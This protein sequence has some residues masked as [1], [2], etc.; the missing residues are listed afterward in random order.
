[1]KF[2]ATTKGITTNFFSPLSFVPVFGS[3]IRDPRYGMGKYQ[4]PGSGMN[5]LDTQ[6]WFLGASKCRFGCWFWICLKKRFKKLCTKY[7]LG[8]S[9][10][11][12]SNTYEKAQKN[13]FKVEVRVNHIL[14]FHD[15]TIK[16]LKL[17]LKPVLWICDI[18][19]RVWICSGS[20]S[21]SFRQWLCLIVEESGSRS[22]SVQ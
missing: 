1:M 8:Q 13:F 7:F 15:Q 14:H 10:T 17:L 21:G 20:R 11:L 9:N 18:L 19:V 2:V 3:E 16:E 22:R 12:K 6:H 4:D 5:I